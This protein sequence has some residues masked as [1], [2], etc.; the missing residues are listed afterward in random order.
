MRTLNGDDQH[1]PASG[2]LALVVIVAVTAGL[3]GCT[4]GKDNTGMQP[5]VTSREAADRVERLV[6]AA[7]SQLPPEVRLEDPYR[8][9]SLP[10]DAPDDGGPEG[11]VIVES[12][13]AVEGLAVSENRPAYFSTVQRFWEDQGYR[14]L[15][16]D[17]RGQMWEMVYEDQ[18]GYV[19]NLATSA[20]GAHM[21][22][23]AQSPCI[24]PNGTPE[25][26]AAP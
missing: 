7:A 11:R 2:W 14:I 22:I 9:E 6:K 3:G 26:E 20:N 13:Y 21:H 17:K 5:T 1:H 16:F 24:W 23:G 18:D 25:P 4:F 10:C 8:T 12:D 19:L 15:R